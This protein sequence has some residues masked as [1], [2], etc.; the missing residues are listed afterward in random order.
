MQLT[1]GI[2]TGK[3]RV[4]KEGTISEEEGIGG[5]GLQ[6][7]MEKWILKKTLDWQVIHGNECG[8]RSWST[9]KPMADF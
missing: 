1:K 2:Q 9:G 8:P 6:R 7:E 4:G 3:H 5:Q